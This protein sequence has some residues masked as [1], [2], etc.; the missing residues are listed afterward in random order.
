[1]VGYYLDCLGLLEAPDFT[2]NK[3]SGF[4]AIQNRADGHPSAG[5]MF[6]QLATLPTD[7]DHK[8]PK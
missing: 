4:I 6:Y 2:K 3:Q 1:M 7:L 8:L 5:Q